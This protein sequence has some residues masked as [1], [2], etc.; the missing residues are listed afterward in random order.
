MR[1]NVYVMILIL[2]VFS[3]YFLDTIE[4]NNENEKLKVSDD[5]EGIRNL[6][7]DCGSCEI[8][9]T[10]EEGMYA[11][12]NISDIKIWNHQLQNWWYYN[13]SSI[14]NVSVERIVQDWFLIVSTFDDQNGK[15][16]VILKI[17]YDNKSEISTINLNIE[18][19]SDPPS[20]WL[21]SMTPNRIHQF[22]NFSVKP[23][24]LDP[25]HNDVHNFYINFI[26]N[27]YHAFHK[28]H[29][30][31]EQLEFY[32]PELGKDWNFNNSDGSF[33]WNVNDQ[34]IWK[35][36]NGMHN[37]IDIELVFTVIDLYGGIDCYIFNLKLVD[38]NEAP[39]KPETITIQQ[40]PYC[41][42]DS[43]NMYTEVVHDP[44]E[45]NLTYYWDFGD[46]NIGTGI[47]IN[48]TY[49]ST[50]QKTIQLWVSDGE[51]Q[52]E[53]ITISINIIEDEKAMH[54]KN[55][56]SLLLMIMLIFFIVIVLSVSTLSLYFL[57]Y[58]K[59]TIK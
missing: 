56:I 11:D 57:V 41:E 49:S 46:G 30:I 4:G 54:D 19:V 48:H 21:S 37:E 26:E 3:P 47:N 18:S 40:G 14:C 31:C 45:D 2:T 35:H 38:I 36:Q 22:E 7:E 50:G 28:N 43:I 9:I 15:Q 59:R 39:S 32:Q 53:N 12:Y 8:K 23:I 20:I 25:D 52:S 44:D 17:A 1:K 27:N 6:V 5:W 55:N 29:T 42:N 16:E 13:V 34:L 51:L 24:V 10:G 58:N 33:S